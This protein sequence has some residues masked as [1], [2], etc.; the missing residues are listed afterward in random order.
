MKFCLKCLACYTDWSILEMSKV[1]ILLRVLWALYKNVSFFFSL[2]IFKYTFNKN[3]ICAFQRWANVA[4]HYSFYHIFLF[5]VWFGWN[6]NYSL[7][8]CIH[9]CMTSLEAGRLSIVLFIL[10]FPLPPHVFLPSVSYLDFSGVY[11]LHH[12]RVKRH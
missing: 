9:N 4:F 1:K 7:L 8:T 2:T 12:W 5:L 11:I 6:V 3:W 10:W